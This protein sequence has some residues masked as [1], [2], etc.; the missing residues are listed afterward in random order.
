MQQTSET[1]RK[2]YLWLSDIVNGTFAS[3]RF[4]SRN[5]LLT[6]LPQPLCSRWIRC[7]CGRGALKTV[8]E[9][10]TRRRLHVVGRRTEHGR[11]S[12]LLLFT[13][14]SCWDFMAFSSRIG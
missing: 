13:I 9:V 2:S 10:V 3:E 8:V 6:E 7:F 4:R 12:C 5:H 11:R 14:T 1:S